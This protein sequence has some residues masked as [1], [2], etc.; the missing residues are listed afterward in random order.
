[1]M[2]PDNGRAWRMGFWALLLGS[3]TIRLLAAGLVGLS[4]DESHYVL[5]SRHLALGY[6]DHPP[7]VGFL[8]AA[9]LSIHDNALFARLGPILCST[10]SLLVLRCLALTLYGSEKVAFVASVFILVMP[11]QQLLGI[12]LLPDAT[13]NLFW[14]GALLAAWHA[15]RS[16]GW[17]AWLIMGALFGGALLSKYHGALFPVCLFGFVATSAP[18]R[19]WLWSP[20]P[21]VAGLI[22]CL[23]FL[24]NV[25]W[26]YQH[27]WISYAFQVGRGGGGGGFALT[28]VFSSI[29]AQ[30]LAASPVLFFVF[31]AA[32]VRAFRSRPALE[33]DRFLFWTSVPV[34][35]VFGLIGMAGRMLPHWPAVGWWAGVLLMAAVV[36]RATD[37]AAETPV[38]RK[39]KAWALAAGVVA[40]VMVAAL[41]VAVAYPV[42][43]GAYGRV[44]DASIRMHVRFPAIPVLPLFESG[45]DVTNDLYGWDAAARFVEK[46][47]E[48]MPN[49][50]RTFVFS[51]RFYTTSQL[52][53][54]LKRDT[55]MLSLGPRPNQYSLWFSP[56]AHKGWDAVFV[57]DNHYMQGGSR[58]RPLFEGM[59]EEPVRT[60]V[61]RRGR[62]AH[63]LHVYRYYGF[64]GETVNE[65]GGK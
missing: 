6:F 25:I 32:C 2:A 31:I 19:R 7:L 38:A 15:T 51:H 16:G 11:I 45:M 44:R 40:M 47:R 14:C 50:S 18:M 58:Y 60:Q 61:L 12:A 29:G 46:V 5:Y 36:V 8:G 1:M 57:D 27:D 35:A 21:Y 20:K 24:P 64:K 39:W 49:A 53:V 28:K 3:L 22:G 23:V 4:T 52:A 17:L 33:A 43:G 13:L 63:T 62:V 41:C 54:F 30:M 9:G 42:L 37:E 48:G 10:M 34:F 55:A 56:S 59:D 26:N 65:Q